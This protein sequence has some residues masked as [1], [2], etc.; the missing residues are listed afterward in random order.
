MKKC[1]LSALLGAVLMFFSLVLI[2]NL[3]SR[4]EAKEYEHIDYISTIT[5]ETCFV[6]SEQGPYWGQDNVGIVDLNTFELLYLPI[7]RYGDHG[8]L[9]EEPA[10]VM[11]RVG[12]MDQE[13]EQYVH[14]EILSD[15]GFAMI[16]MSGVN[17]SIDRDFIQSY[18]C[19]L[20][21]DTINNMSF[22]TRPS[23]EYAIVS[24]EERTIQ[25]L[26]NSHLWFSAGNY[27]ID[28]D[29][30]SD[31]TLDLLIFYCPPRYA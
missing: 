28:C 5:S 8:E 24:F 6:C 1:I 2:A 9:I 10:G 11:Q 13:K 18:L 14:A 29:F 3:D 22:S 27:G 21:L 19:Q 20:C 4:K 23:A 12:M 16:D 17:Y 30:N 25:P 15:N 31:G 26:V 7:N